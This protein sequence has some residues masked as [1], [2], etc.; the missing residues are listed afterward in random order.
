MKPFSHGAA[1]GDVGGLRADSSDPLLHRLGNAFR[2]IVGTDMPGHAA[3]NEQVR[4]EL[5]D[6]G[7]IV[8]ALRKR[9]V[10]RYWPRAA[11]A[12]RSETDN[13]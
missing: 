1:G 11:Q 8:S 5:D 7:F 13:T 10:E 4:E 12:R 9:C 3:Q 6:V 2:A